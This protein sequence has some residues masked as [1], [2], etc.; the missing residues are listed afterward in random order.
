MTKAALNVYNNETTTDLLTIYLIKIKSHY[1]LLAA[2]AL[3]NQKIKHYLQN[4]IKKCNN[5]ALLY[6]MLMS[7]KKPSEVDRENLRKKKENLE[8]FKSKLIY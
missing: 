3:Y 8:A 2:A 6:K 4:Q 1:D 7:K 5:K